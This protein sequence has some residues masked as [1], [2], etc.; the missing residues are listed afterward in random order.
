MPL[1]SLIAYVKIKNIDFYISNKDK[2]DLLF[3]VAVTSY[4]I[5]F[6]A[7]FVMRADFIVTALMLSYMINT[8]AASLINRVDKISVH[9]WG[10]SGPAVSLLYLCG[11]TAFAGAILV[12]LLVGA[13]RIRVKAHTLWQVLSAIA[14][15]IPLTIFIIYY[16]APLIL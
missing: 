4:F 11:Y 10:I 16:L 12:A 1:A 3:Y 14:V 2:R 13:S 8:L 6:M 9:V 7:L 15:S 5:G